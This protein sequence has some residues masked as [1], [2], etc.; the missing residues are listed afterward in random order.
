MGWVDGCGE[1]V[2]IGGFDGLR[3]FFLE[4]GGGGGWGGV[5]L[6]SL[7]GGN[8]AN[9]EWLVIFVS[10]AGRLLVM[11]EVCFDSGWIME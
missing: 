5:I 4:G 11:F 8:S 9:G 2:M 7:Y 1:V 3:S 10:A 6:G